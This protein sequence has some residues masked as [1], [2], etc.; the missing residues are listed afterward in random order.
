MTDIF[1]DGAITTL[2]VGFITTSLVPATTFS[3]DLMSRIRKG[4]ASVALSRPIDPIAA[5]ASALLGKDATVTVLNQGLWRAEPA[6][7]PVARRLLKRKRELIAAASSYRTFE[8]SKHDRWTGH[9]RHKYAKLNQLI[10]KKAK[11]KA[12]LARK[13]QAQ[14]TLVFTAILRVKKKTAGRPAT[15]AKKAVAPKGSQAKTGDSCSFLLEDLPLTTYP[16]CP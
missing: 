2:I 14:V 7:L 5:L 15:K 12:D 10:R 16:M 8:L 9:R 1:S 11:S 3:E 6:A 13:E 4:L